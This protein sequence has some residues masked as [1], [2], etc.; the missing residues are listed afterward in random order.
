MKVFV[1]NDIDFRFETLCINRKNSVEI[2]HDILRFVICTLW[3]F[4]SLGLPYSK[5]SVILAK[6]LPKQD[7]REIPF[8]QEIPVKFHLL[9]TQI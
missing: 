3:N 4:T 9:G 1:S 6:S 5:Y 2:I 8:A 7:S